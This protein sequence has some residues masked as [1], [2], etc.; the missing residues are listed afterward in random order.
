MMIKRGSRM[1]D[2]IRDTRGFDRCGCARDVCRC[3]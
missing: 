3:D 2:G 1:L